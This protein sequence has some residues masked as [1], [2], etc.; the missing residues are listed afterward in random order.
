MCIRDR[1]FSRATRTRAK[2]L[3]SRISSLVSIDDESINFQCEGISRDVYV[4]QLSYHRNNSRYRLTREPMMESYSAKDLEM[5]EDFNNLYDW[6]KELYNKILHVNT[7]EFKIPDSR[8]IMSIVDKE[9]K[10]G[11]SSFVKWLC[12]NYPM[13]IARL[14]FGTASQLRSAVF[15]MGKRKC[16]IIDLPRTK[17]RG[18]SIFDLLS[19]IEDMKNGFISSS[20]YGADKQLM[21]DPP[22]VIVFSNNPLPYNSLSQ[23]RWDLYTL[24][25]QKEL[26]KMQNLYSGEEEEKDNK[27]DISTKETLT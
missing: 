19:V 13:D 26:V 21:M 22:F 25:D 15:N 3:Q 2:A 7:G 14:S 1:F 16:Y 6:Q 9:G 8:E 20:M 18:D 4:S 5:F 11:K 23:D 24:S 27:E 17:G 12:Y 10:K